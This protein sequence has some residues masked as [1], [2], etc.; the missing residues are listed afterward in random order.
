MPFSLFPDEAGGGGEEEEDCIISGEKMRLTSSKRY[1]PTR[2]KC[3]QQNTLPY[4]TPMHWSRNHKHVNAL[5]RYSPTHRG[6]KEEEK[7]ERGDCMRISMSGGVR[8]GA[9]YSL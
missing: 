9:P 8:K 4:R 7:A 2:M 1:G 6:W 5:A 3:S